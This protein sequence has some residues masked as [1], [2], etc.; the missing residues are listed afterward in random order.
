MKA[1]TK[2]LTLATL[3]VSLSSTFVTACADCNKPENAQKSR[4]IPKE[5]HD[6]HRK[7]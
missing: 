4:C 6:A 5:K 7:I 1:L 3:L 2:S